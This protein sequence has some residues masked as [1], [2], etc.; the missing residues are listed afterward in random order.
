MSFDCLTS[1]GETVINGRN[2]KI[3]WRAWDQ[4]KGD[5]W[6]KFYSSD[7]RQWG[8]EIG[9]WKWK[10]KGEHTQEKLLHRCTMTHTHQQ[11]NEWIFYSIYSEWTTATWMNFRNKILAK[12]T[13]PKMLP[14]KIHKFLSN[15]KTKLNNMV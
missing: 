4:R 3:D 1:K 6:G 14:R 7:K 10:C 8:F 5:Q 12:V 2:M 9:L 15:L 11:R 13:S